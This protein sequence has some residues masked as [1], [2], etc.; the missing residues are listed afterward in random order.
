MRAD[1]TREQRLTQRDPGAEGEVVA[2]S[3]VVLPPQIRA[4]VAKPI[5]TIA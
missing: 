2:N 4:A 5:T 3:T 1:E